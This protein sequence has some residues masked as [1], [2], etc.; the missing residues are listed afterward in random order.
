MIGTSEQSILG[1]VKAGRAMNDR[2]CRFTS[3]F[4]QGYMSDIIVFQPVGLNIT[5]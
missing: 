1:P 5:I 2:N 4:K 3:C